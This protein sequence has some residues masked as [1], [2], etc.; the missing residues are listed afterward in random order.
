MWFPS[1]DKFLGI[2]WLIQSKFKKNNKTTL[3]N[4]TEYLCRMWIY[5]QINGHIF[6]ISPCI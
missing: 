3:L 5:C 4:Q 2:A 6:E 1:N